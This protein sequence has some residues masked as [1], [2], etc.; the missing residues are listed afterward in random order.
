M[1]KNII[2]F[3]VVNLAIFGPMAAAQLLPGWLASLLLL[4]AISA[5]IGCSL[6]ALQ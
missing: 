5:G 4:G 1:K 2:G 6:E 3:I